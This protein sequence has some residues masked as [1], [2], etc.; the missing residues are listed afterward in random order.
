MADAPKIEIEKVTKALNLA[1]DQNA[2]AGEYLL[3]ET[4]KYL[5]TLKGLT[6]QIPEGVSDTGPFTIL[7]LAQNMAAFMQGQLMQVESV[8]AMSRPVEPGDP[9]RVDGMSGG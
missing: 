7:S 8:V 9:I 3:D 1:R 6:D 4:K 2:S 5:T